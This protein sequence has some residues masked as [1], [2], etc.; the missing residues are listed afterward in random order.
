MLLSKYLARARADNL[1]IV[2]GA[3][4]VSN[5]ITIGPQFVVIVMVLG[6]DLET[7]AG[8]FTV[9]GLCAVAVL[10]LQPSTVVALLAAIAGVAILNAATTKIARIFF[11]VIPIRLFLVVCLLHLR[12]LDL[13]LGLHW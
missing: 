6:K 5:E 2:S 10:A 1:V 4:L 3:L 8:S 12:Q 7:L 13:L 11:I 9:A